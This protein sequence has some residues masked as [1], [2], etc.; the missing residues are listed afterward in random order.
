MNNA[1]ETWGKTFSLVE[2][3]NEK[4]WEMWL[5][6]MGSMSWSQEQMENMLSKYIEQRK[7]ARDESSRLIDEVMNQ[8]KRNQMQ[9]QKMVQEAVNTALENV[10]IPGNKYFDDLNARINE[11]SKKLENL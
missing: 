1:Q 7:L 8:V 2:S 3:I 11:L 4:M 9:M 6:S 10:D 5:F